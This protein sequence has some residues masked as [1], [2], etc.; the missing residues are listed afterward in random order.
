MLGVRS[1]ILMFL[2]TQMD[3]HENGV[4]NVTRAEWDVLNAVN[5]LTLESVVQGME[6]VLA[7]YMVCPRHLCSQMASSPVDNYPRATGGGG[8]KDRK[9]FRP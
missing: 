2:Q 4:G 7:L 5:F 6:F 8:G 9:A 1:E 3:C